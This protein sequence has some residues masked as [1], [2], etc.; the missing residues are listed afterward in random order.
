M[1]KNFMRSRFLSFLLYEFFSNLPTFFRNDYSELLDYMICT[2][3]IASKCVKCNLKQMTC[4]LAIT[5]Q[6]KAVLREN[7]QLKISERSMHL[8]L[9]R[10][11][12]HSSETNSTKSQN[13]S[14]IILNQ[15][16]KSILH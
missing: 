2:P 14:I 11:T 5:C 4:L 10:L 8:V 13:C 16:I 7:A 3:R 12:G 9:V 1:N 15:L 6:L